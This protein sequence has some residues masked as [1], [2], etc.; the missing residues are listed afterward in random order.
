M[1][2]HIPMR[3][4]YIASLQ[5]ATAASPEG[6]EGSGGHP[7]GEARLEAL[8]LLGAAW[9]QPPRIKH[10]VLDYSDDCEVLEI[11]LPAEFKTVELE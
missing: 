6:D 2:F 10:T 9:L 7:L 3:E 4:H 8:G 11:I 1:V 5:G